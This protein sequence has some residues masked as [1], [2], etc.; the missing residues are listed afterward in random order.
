MATLSKFALLRSSSSTICSVWISS[1][2]FAV[3]LPLVIC[4]DL[5]TCDCRQGF[6]F[7]VPVYLYRS[8]CAAVIVCIVF[9]SSSSVSVS[10]PVINGSGGGIG[11]VDAAALSFLEI[12]LGFAGLPMPDAN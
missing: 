11:A 6:L 4:F 9:T 10:L 5:V 12:G 7:V 1:S 2:S 3:F 8:L